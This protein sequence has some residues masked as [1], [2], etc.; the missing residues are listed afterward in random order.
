MKLEMAKA[1]DRVSWEFLQ[2]ILLAFGFAEEW[3]NWILSCV[4]STSYSHLQFVDDTAFM[5][6]SRVSEAINFRW[7]LDIYLRASGQ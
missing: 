1:Y 4:T 6:S 3:V 7:A 5:G 2:N